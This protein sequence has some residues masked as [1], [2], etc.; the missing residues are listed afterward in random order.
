MNISIPDKIY[1]ERFQEQMPVPSF[2]KVVREF[3][4]RNQY[5]IKLYSEKLGYT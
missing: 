2:K 5:Q 3:V 4:I 1:R